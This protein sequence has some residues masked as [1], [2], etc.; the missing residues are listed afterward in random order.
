MM[1]ISSDGPFVACTG[2]QLQAAGEL[3]LDVYPTS[4]PT[5]GLEPLYLKLNNGSSVIY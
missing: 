5:G 2:V 1:F 4:Q 3:K